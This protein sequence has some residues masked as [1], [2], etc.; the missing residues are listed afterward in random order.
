MDRREKRAAGDHRLAD[1]ARDGTPQHAD[2]T[3]VAA[4]DLSEV[5]EQQEFLCNEDA[6]Q[7]AESLE[8]RQGDF[9]L[10]NE[11][12]NEEFGGSLWDRFAHELARYGYAVVIAWLK[13]GEMFTQCKKKN[14]WPGAPPAFF[15]D[16]DLVSLANDTVFQA[17]LNFRD[18][19]LIGEG[20]SLEGGASLKTYFIGTCVLAF[21]NYYR[22]WCTEKANERKLFGT[23][24][25]TEDVAGLTS[26]QDDPGELVVRQ[27]RTWSG[28]DAIR[29]D[30]TK[31]AV[32]L[33]EL[34]YSYDEM[35][36][37]L[38]ETRGS[39]KQILARQRRRGEKASEGG[40]SHA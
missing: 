33:Q 37:L 2:T 17:I 4:S 38:G 10:R 14:C 7:A 31:K 11:L 36:E 15:Q 18:R 16:D 40:G 8:R 9:N 30:R 13:T 19:A 32:L 24:V 26:S 28:F 12:A 35:A 39:V 22:K 25:H 29:D 1:P 20:W 34:G 5:E 21:P 6:R 3:D 27:L 23:A